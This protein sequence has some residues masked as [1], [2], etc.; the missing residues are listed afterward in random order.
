MNGGLTS[1]VAA[2][3]G[4]Q[5][6]KQLRAVYG[7]CV[8]KALYLSS[9]LADAALHTITTRGARIVGRPIPVRSYYCALC[10]GWHLTSQ[11]PRQVPRR[12][13]RHQQLEWVSG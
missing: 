13:R 10:G 7:P 4:L 5:S 6:T 9:S 3:I 1:T 2:Y 12:R 8:G 11:E